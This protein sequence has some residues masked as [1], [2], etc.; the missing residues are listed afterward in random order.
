MNKRLFFFLVPLMTLVG[1]GTMYG[2]DPIVKV[3]EYGYDNWADALAAWTNGTTLTLLADRE[4]TAEIEV[5]VAEGSKA[6][7]L[8]LNGY[9]LKQTKADKCLFVIG[10]GGSLTIIDN[11]PNRS[12]HRFNVN[13]TTHKAVL[14]GEGTYSFSGGYLIGG[15]GHN[16]GLSDPYR[17]GAILVNGGTL[18]MT[19][20]T[21]LGN[22]APFGGAVAVQAGS[23]SMTGGA[24]MYNS[25]VRGGDTYHGGSAIWVQ[26][27]EN[28]QLTLGGTA[29]I[30]RN[31]TPYISNS[32]ETAGQVAIFGEGS[33]GTACTLS[34]GSLQVSEG[35]NGKNL[36]LLD[37]N[38]ATVTG[39][40][41][42][43]ATIGVTANK[44]PRIFTSGY[45]T[46]NSGKD[47][48]LYFESD[49]PE[50]AVYVSGSEATLGR[51][52]GAASGLFSV[53]ADRK[54][55]FAMH[56]VPGL[57]QWSWANA[58]TEA[59][60][61][62]WRVLTGDEWSYL[63]ITRD[64]E[65]MSKNNLGTVD[66]QKGLVILPDD[67][68]QPVGVPEFKPVT[69]GKY[70]DKNVYTAAEWDLM[71][72][73]GAVFLPCEGYSTDSV[74]A[75]DA[76][77]H[78]AYWACNQYNDNTGYSIHFDNGTIHDFNYYT[79]KTTY[80]SVRLVR[81]EATIPELDEEHY[82]AAFATD[83][84]AASEKDFA[85][86]NRTLRKDSTLYTLCLPFDVPNVD[87]SPLAGAEIFTFEGGTVSGSTG[88]EV[89]HLHLSRL[90][91]KR[92]TQ[93]VPYLLRWAKV[94]ATQTMTRLCFYNVQ[95]WDDDTSAATDPGNT[96][97]KCHGVYPKAHIPG[98]T[99]GSVA[100]YNFFLG[101]KNQLYWPDDATYPSGSEHDMKGFRAYF[102]ITLSGYPASAPSYRNIKM[103][104]EIDGEADSPTDMESVQS[105]GISV[106]KQL[107]DGQVIL[108]I[109]GQM[110]DLQGKQIK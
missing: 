48:A 72:Q 103:V 13:E 36:I 78:G 44:A 110:F 85:I 83:L 62:G 33:S 79:L 74:T 77:D 109:D 26:R 21:I 63:M 99:S 71:A 47:P 15:T 69:A 92:L 54:V 55:R 102:Y 27:D 8:D 49:D 22:S 76:A 7:T 98:Y 3:N 6:L 24:I 100:H 65:G 81:N 9:G 30:L 82:S 20:G 104:W 88:N 60:A 94:G 84:A 91:G 37:D 38:V 51:A 56:N 25:N 31:Y 101:A 28:A 45:N 10:S 29:R 32:P 87:A 89:L 5:A 64:G 41:A 14:N 80:Y 12:D 1:V 68:V 11:A 93:G 95:N 97:L 46:N 61:N 106:Q 75:T 34:G 35:E 43:D 2:G 42:A 66:G 108:I 52:G 4:I 17:G 18:T 57:V 67:W 58:H 19:G 59:D 23:F 105:S 90:E 96:T 40:F 86:V 73:S 53:A 16:G 39:A 70:Y 50:F 107:R